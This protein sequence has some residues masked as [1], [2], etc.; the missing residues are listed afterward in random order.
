L[1]LVYFAFRGPIFPNGQRLWDY[2]VCASSSYLWVKGEDPFAWEAVKASWVERGGAP[3]ITKDIGWLYAIVPPTTLAVLSPFAV[4]PVAIGAYLYLAVT[5]LLVGI[6]AWLC[7]KWADLRGGSAWRFYLAAI[8]VSVPATLGLY[9]GNPTMLAAPCLM[10]GSYLIGTG[11]AKSSEYVGGMLIGLGVACKIQIGLPVL[12]FWLVWGRCRG[13]L[14]AMLTAAAII[15]IAVGRLAVADIEWLAT[16]VENVRKT[17]SPGGLNDYVS[18]KNPDDLVN[19]Q[20]AL[21]RL[22]HSRAATDNLSLVLWLIM[23]GAVFAAI[24]R[25]KWRRGFEPQFLGA[26]GLLTLIPVY[27]RTYDAIVLLPLLAVFVA[28]LERRRAWWLGWIGLVLL[29]SLLVPAGLPYYL[30]KRGMLPNLEESTLLSSL[31]IGH[32]G[33]CILGLAAVWIWALLTRCGEAVPAGVQEKS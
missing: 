8:L 27:H 3:G 24:V 6:S 12:A 22:V 20:V 33:W 4:L 25:S 30:T 26:I 17:N 28:G 29:G 14:A 1:A 31:I 15:G 21:Y 19:L 10:I 18:A 7:G 13:A 5:T 16:W 9:S 32:K 23:S 11:K 2:A